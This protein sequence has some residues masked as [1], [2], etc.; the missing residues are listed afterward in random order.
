ME[1]F[2]ER[3]SSEYDELKERVDKLGVFLD[4]DIYKT[5]NLEEQ[6]DLIT[7]YHAMIIYKTI[8]RKRLKR[9]GIDKTTDCIK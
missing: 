4:G 2:V 3:M 5:L 9:Q 1:A 8:L 7:Q 6:D